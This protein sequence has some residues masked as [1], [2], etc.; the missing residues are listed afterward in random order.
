[1]AQD[2]ANMVMKAVGQVG[3][4]V[5]MIAFLALIIGNI[6]GNAV[7]TAITIINVT[8]LTDAFGGFVTALVGF[9]A[10][11]G[12]VVAV[13]WLFQ[14]VKSLFSKKEGGITSFAG[15]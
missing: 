2:R 1:M 11:I 8:E 5:L 15:N 3:A 7:F 10:I 4:V 12:I 13:V 14:Y 6:L 9:L